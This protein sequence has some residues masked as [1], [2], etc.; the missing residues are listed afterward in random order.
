[1]SDS[2]PPPYSESHEP[3]PLY[4][5]SQPLASSSSCS[6]DRDNPLTFHVGLRELQDS[7]V[8]IKHL[9]LHLCFLGALHDLRKRAESAA[10]ASW[11]S[12]IRELDGERRWSWFVNLAVERSVP[13]LCLTYNSL[14]SNTSDFS[15]GWN[16]FPHL[17]DRIR[18]P[19]SFGMICLLSTFG[20]YYM[21]TC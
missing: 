5:P 6:R 8:Q 15:A 11:P 14:T 10:D 19:S 16:I 12:L 18:S 2:E 13:W 17:Q 4:S 7:L 21:R 3:S 9:K 1:M 20:W